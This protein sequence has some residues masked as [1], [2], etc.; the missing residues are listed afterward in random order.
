[1]NEKAFKAS[2]ICEPGVFPDCPWAIDLFSVRMKE[3]K[4]MASRNRLFLRFFGVF[5][6][7]LFDL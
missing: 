5:I 6:I 4:V 7:Q 2:F 1:L 3:N